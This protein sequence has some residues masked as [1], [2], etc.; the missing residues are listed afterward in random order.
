MA[1]NR[2]EKVKLQILQVNTILYFLNTLPNRGEIH[3]KRNNYLNAW[4]KTV[5]WFNRLWK[6]VILPPIIP[7]GSVLPKTSKQHLS[8][9]MNQIKLFQS[10]PYGSKLSVNS[11]SK[12]LP[13]K[14]F[15]SQT[16]AYRNFSGGPL[17]PLGE[18]RCI[19]PCFPTFLAVWQCTA[20]R[21]GDC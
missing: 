20:K 18:F 11:W 16:N 1:S 17:K 9:L 2:K 19:K 6:W 4:I 5:L 13:K 8:Q 14:F 3:T 7:C 12:V 10:I 21:N 15:M